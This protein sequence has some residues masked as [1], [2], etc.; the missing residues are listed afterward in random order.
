M[1]TAREEAVGIISGGRV[2]ALE[3]EGLC[4]VRVDELRRV[5]QLLD[6]AM[7]DAATWTARC[8]LLDARGM[9]RGMHRVALMCVA[10]TRTDD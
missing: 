6:E 2:Q 10:R 5:G 4:V 7:H 8:A 3:A 9:L 1:T